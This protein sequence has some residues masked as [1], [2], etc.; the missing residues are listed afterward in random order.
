MS[1]SPSPRVTTFARGAGS[2]RLLSSKVVLMDIG[3]RS[4]QDGRER[5]GPVDGDQ[6]RKPRATEHG[7]LSL[8]TLPG[9][10][11][12]LPRT[13]I[14]TSMVDPLERGR[15]AIVH[16]PITWLT[17]PMAIAAVKTAMTKAMNPSAMVRFFPAAP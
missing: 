13:I 16:D 1:V 5:T 15:G 4:G 8:H 11:V 14:R 6:S 17:T 9:P 3:R 10:I 12:F 2:S 7:Y